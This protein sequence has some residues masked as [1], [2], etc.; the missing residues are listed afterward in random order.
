MLPHT[1]KRNAFSN[2]KYVE[3]SFINWFLPHLMAFLGGLH[4]I[5]KVIDL[6]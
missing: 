4:N 3:V 5:D 2:E 1:K 6:V